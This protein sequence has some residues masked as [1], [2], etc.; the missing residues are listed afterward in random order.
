LAAVKDGIQQTETSSTKKP[1]GVSS[2]MMPEEAL[3]YSKWK[4]EKVNANL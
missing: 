1:L 3:F 2:G 4:M